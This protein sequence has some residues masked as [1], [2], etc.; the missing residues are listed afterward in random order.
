VTL[1]DHSQWATLFPERPA[2]T[3]EEISARLGEL[4]FTQSADAR[5]HFRM[6]APAGWR[7]RPNE[8]AGNPEGLLAS[9]VS[10]VAATAEI[11]VFVDDVA[12]E[13]SPADWTLHRLE[14]EGCSLWARRQAPTP[15]GT[16]ADLL[17]RREAPGGAVIARTNMAKDG[18]RIFT[19]TCRA[20]ED[21][22]PR[23]AGDFS[24]VLATFRLSSPEGAP[25]AEELASYCYLYP[26]VVGFSYPASWT[27]AHES[28][29]QTTCDVRLDSMAGD[30]A[31]G[32]ILLSARTGVRPRKLAADGFSALEAGGARFEARTDLEPC[33]PPERFGEA[34]TMTATGTRDGRDIEAR[35]FVLVSPE[36]T[37][38]LG[39][40]G[41]TRAA[42]AFDWMVVERAFEMV[43]HTVYA[44]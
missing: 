20:R 26:A 4:R 14:R 3:P 24:A 39:S 23:W 29:G 21:E 6:L 7:W 11:A 9:L 18:K 16:M 22:Y 35:A 17:T 30:P 44:V 19:I 13:V 36:A 34:W 43:R 5:L 42:S 37:L 28:L 2:G 25:L 32:S 40:C 41:P 33:P 12:R 15:I 27:V 8:E 10:D 31:A 1:L 38:L